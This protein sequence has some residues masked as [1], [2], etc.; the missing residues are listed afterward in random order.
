MAL[1]SGRYHS[2]RRPNLARR[3]AI[4]ARVRLDLTCSIHRMTNSMRL[5]QCTILHLVLATDSS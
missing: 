4:S 5:V 3:R 2:N 1:G